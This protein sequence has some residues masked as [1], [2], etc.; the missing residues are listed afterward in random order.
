MKKCIKYL[1]VLLKRITHVGK[2]GGLPPSFLHQG[3]P[4]FSQWESPD[5]VEGII[6]GTVHAGDDP[7]WKNSGAKTKGD[8]ALWS[9]AGCGM[10]CTKMLVAHVKKVTIPLVR[11]GEKCAEYGGYKLP[12][13]D[14]QGLMYAPYVEYMDREF[15][16]RAKVV[17]PLLPREIMYELG[18]ANYVI[19]SVSPKIRHPNTTP[20]SK[21]GHLVLMLGYDLDKLEFYFHNPSGFK[22]KTQQYATISFADFNKFFANRG[23][24]VSGTAS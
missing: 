19:A 21:G 23:I 9:A 3:V 4:Y 17:L 2:F 6:G 24:V 18:R 14:T 5:L 12:L 1:R 7:N 11:L 10:A 15:G 13:Q 8:Y 22:Q 16:L 20:S